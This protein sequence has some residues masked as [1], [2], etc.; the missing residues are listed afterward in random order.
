MIKRLILVYQELK[1]AVISFFKKKEIVNYD[2]LIEDHNL[3]LRIF[4][5]EVG[6]IRVYVGSPFFSFSYCHNDFPRPVYTKHGL[7]LLPHAYANAHNVLAL[8]DVF[9]IIDV[10]AINKMDEKS[11]VMTKIFFNE[12]VYLVDTAEITHFSTPIDKMNY[13]K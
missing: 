1:K 2:K 9:V 3:L 6:Q 11:P 12:N 8:N 10:Y 7:E 13:E 5:L 4:P